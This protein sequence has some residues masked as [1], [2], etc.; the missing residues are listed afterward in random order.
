MPSPET[1]IDIDRVEYRLEANNTLALRVH[2]ATPIDQ[3]TAF[4]EAWGQSGGSDYSYY[5]WVMQSGV[6][7]LQGYNS[8]VGFMTIADVD[9]LHHQLKLN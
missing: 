6:G 8:G 3:Q 9:V 7:T 1:A 4:L 5:R 2:P